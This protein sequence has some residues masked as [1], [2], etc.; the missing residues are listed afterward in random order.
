[1]E[2]PRLLAVLLLLANLNQYASFFTTN[3]FCPYQLQPC[4]VAPVFLKAECDLATEGTIECDD[5]LQPKPAATVWQV[6]GELA[7]KTNSIN[8]GQGF[9]DWSPPDFVLDSLRGV[10]DTP[11]HQYTRPAG[12]PPLVELIGARYSKHF[13]RIIDPFNEVAIT[14]GASQALYLSLMTLTKPGDEVVMF[15]PFFELYLKQLKLTAASPVFVPLGG[16]GRASADDPW[17]LDVDLLRKAITEKTKVLILNSPHNPTGKVFT[18][19]E[20]EAIAQV[21][22]DNPQIIVLSDEVYK[23]SV[24]SALGKGDSSAEGHYHFARIKDMFDRTITLSSCGKTFSVTGWQVGWAVGPARYVQQMQE[25]LPCLQFCSSTPI[26]HALTTALQVADLPYKGF[27]NYYSW[28]RAQFLRKR[29][30]LE[31]GLRAVGVEPLASNGGFFLMGKLPLYKELTSG[32]GAGAP[33][34]EPY[35]W[36]FCRMMAERYGIS[37]I[38]ASPFFSKEEHNSVGPMARFAFCKKDE[39][40][41]GARDRLLTIAA[42]SAFAKSKTLS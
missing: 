26:Q 27:P 14:V 2:A 3:R 5:A 35:D 13:D 1:M 9:P 12:H 32:V 4:L 41:I 31:E 16:P 30:I 36:R 7:A 29:M 23:F 33:L 21:V 40:L 20:L 39:T 15:E 8:L 24:Y 6:F 38:P 18:L 19:Q 10:V 37:A 25:M 17:G 11:Y 22:R 28:L 42:S 34:D